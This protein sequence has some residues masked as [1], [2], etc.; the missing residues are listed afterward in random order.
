MAPVV[1]N[2]CRP[3]DKQGDTEAGAAEAGT[4]CETTGKYEQEKSGVSATCAAPCVFVAHNHPRAPRAVHFACHAGGEA[5]PEAGIP[6]RF[7]GN[8]LPPA[9]GNGGTSLK[10]T[11]IATVQTIAHSGA[12]G[13]QD[14]R[15]FASQ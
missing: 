7:S 1:P 4:L 8:Q 9:R 12:A 6:D 15:R 11:L 2:L 10:G 5:L 13:V 3:L 14:E